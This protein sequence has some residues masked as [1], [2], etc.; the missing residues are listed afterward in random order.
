MLSIIFQII[1]GV[2]GGFAGGFQTTLNSV[3]SGKIGDMGSVFITYCSGGI[4]IFLITLFSGKLD[5]QAWRTLPWYLFLAGPC[6]LAIVGSLG[7]TAA[8]LG[9]TA[10]LS[11]FIVASLSFGLAADHFGWLGAEVR[12]MDISRFIGLTALIVG[13]W[14]VIR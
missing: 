1:V 2:L 3:L 8:R 12:P 5:V 14:L 6:G 11:I 9:T 4:A 7:Y 10:A 13:T